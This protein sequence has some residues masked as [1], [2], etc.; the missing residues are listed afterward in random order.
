M[1]TGRSVSKSIREWVVVR[2][3]R[4][5]QDRQRLQTS[6]L[7]THSNDHPD[8]PTPKSVR[9]RLQL[10]ACQLGLQHSIPGRWEPGLLG[11]IQQPWTVVQPKGNSQLLLSP[12]EVGTN[13][14]LAFA[15]FGQDSRLP[16]RH[17][18]G[19]F[20]L[21]QRRPSLVTPPWFKVPAHSDPV[22]HWNFRKADWKRFCLLTGVNPWRDC[23][24]RTHQ[25]LR[26]H[27]RIFARAYFLQLN[28]VS[29]V[30][31]RRT[32]CHAGTK[33]A[34]PSIAPLSEPQWG[35]PL[36]DPPHPYS[37]DQWCA[38]VIFFVSESSQGHEP[39]E[40]ESSK[41]F[42]SRVRVESQEGSSH[43]ES[44]VYKLESMS[45]HTK[46][47]TFPICLWL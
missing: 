32:M 3:R 25:I 26:G 47:Q 35:L 16:D 4:R 18:L 20:Q 10:P 46:F 5:L 9:W 11:N 23:H 21:S 29:H 7:T 44:L 6:T 8:V 27:T 41:I 45:S 13:P 42:S 30:A 14:D 2:R 12:L 38:R 31:V 37:L 39:F 22:K 19:K 1:V 33:S 15:S 34:R 28:N 36:T 17:V 40:S 43:L 24:L